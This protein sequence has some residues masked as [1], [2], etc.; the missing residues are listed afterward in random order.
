MWAEDFNSSNG[1]LLIT[2]NIKIKM[3]KVAIF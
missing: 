1:R 2:Y 3:I